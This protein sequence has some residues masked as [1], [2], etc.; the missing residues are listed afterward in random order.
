[1]VYGSVCSGIEAASVAWKPLGWKPA[2]F[3]EIESFPKAVLAHHYP[4][5]PDLD[6]MTKITE[7]EVFSERPIEL[8]VGETPCQSFSLAGLRKGLDD[9]RGNLALEF[10]K[11]VDRARPR[12]VVW[13]NVPGV[14]SSWTDATDARRQ[15]SG[16]WQNNDFDTFIG[17]LAELGYGC[18]WRVLDAQYFGLAQRRKRVFVVGYLGD[19]RP[20]AAVL[21]ER[22]SMSGN[23]AP[24]REKGQTAPTLPSRSSG[25]G[26]LGTDCEIDGGLI[27]GTLNGNGKAAGSAT[28]QDAESGMLVYGGNNT[29]GSIDVAPA[30]NA[31]GGSGRMDF[32]TEPLIAHTLRSEHDAS[33]DGTGRGTPLVPT[34]FMAGQG[35]KA[36]S[37]AASEKGGSDTQKSR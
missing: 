23:P 21:L 3:S 16:C 18:F 11:I 14:L 9:P 4:D 13:E 34:V 29:Q 24:R 19:W 12:W 25:G 8:L 35:S 7:T 32:A 15:G 2:W 17:A 36:G 6:D 10:L 37:V 33:E 26:G 22:Q 1:M 5:V 31:K 28:Q 27:A 20:A 30:C